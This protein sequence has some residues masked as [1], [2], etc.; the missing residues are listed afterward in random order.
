MDVTLLNV[1]NLLGSSSE[2]SVDDKDS[3]V[4]GVLCPNPK[5]QFLGTEL[6]RHGTRQEAD[7]TFQK[8][9]TLPGW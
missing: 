3:R 7:P 2:E 5:L 6:L 9:A 4:Q 8:R 1:I